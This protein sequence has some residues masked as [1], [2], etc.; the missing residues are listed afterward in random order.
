MVGETQGTGPVATEVALPP[1]DD[2]RDA[3]RQMRETAGEGTVR[4]IDMILDRPLDVLGMTLVEIADAASVSDSMVIKV[5]KRANLHGFQSLKVALAHSLGSPTNG[6]QEDL[7]L[8]DDYGTII[9]KTFG[10]NIQALLDTELTLKPDLLQQAVE[11]LD[12]A[13]KIDIYGI[14]SAAPIAEDAYYRLIRIGRDARISVDSHLQV[15]TASLANERTAVLTISH[16]GSTLETLDATKLAKKAGAKVVV[17]TG[18]KQS[19]I[20]QHADVV[21]QT[22]ARETKLRTEAM[23]SRIAQLSIVDALIGALALKRHDLS[24]ATQNTTFEALSLRRV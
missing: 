7:I 21:L 8:G 9:R 20:Q 19:P 22:R 14:G 5:L 1:A 11:I 17:I 16:S 24:V 6:V 12:A 2:I 4:I 3:L 23:T 10:A 13:E 15:T 18:Y